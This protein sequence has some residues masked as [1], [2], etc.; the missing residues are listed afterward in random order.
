MREEKVPE[1][2]HQDSVAQSAFKVNA[3]SVLSL[4]TSLISQLVVAWAFGTGAEMD[5]FLT[6]YVIPVYLQAVFLGGLSLT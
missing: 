3:G 5:A 2:L 4:I 1:I 6:A